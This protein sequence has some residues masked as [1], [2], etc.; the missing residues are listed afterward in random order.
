M[1]NAMIDGITNIDEDLIVNYFKTK[2]K[3]KRK[4]NHVVRKIRQYGTVAASLVLMIIAVMCFVLNDG[5]QP[6]PSL[7]GDYGYSAESK[8][9][10]VGGISNSEYGTIRYVKHDNNTITL[11]LDKK[12]DGYI[13][14][15]LFGYSRSNTSEENNIYCGTT[16]NSV[17]KNDVIIVKDGIEVYVDGVVCEQLPQKAGKYVI[18]INYKKLKDECEWLDRGIYVHG[19][20]YFIIN[21]NFAGNDP[22]DDSPSDSGD[23]GGLTTYPASENTTNDKLLY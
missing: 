17:I 22:R 23:S 13:Y 1:N 7:P 12:T 21:L 14:A 5:I 9:Y 19:F 3:L 8:L 11:E 10:N 16:N 18:E 6:V 4:N 15:T 20:E 2:E